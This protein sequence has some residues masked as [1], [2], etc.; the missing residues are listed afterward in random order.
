MGAPQI[1]GYVF[2]SPDAPAADA[3]DWTIAG[4]R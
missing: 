2:N 4:P 3:I 1:S